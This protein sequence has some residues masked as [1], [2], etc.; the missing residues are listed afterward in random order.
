MRRWRDRHRQ[1]NSY[2]DPALKQARLEEIAVSSAGA[3]RFGGSLWKSEALMALFA[4]ERPQVVVVGRAVYV[5]TGDPAAYIRAIWWAL[6]MYWR[7]I[8]TMVWRILCTRAVL[9]GGN[10]TCRLMSVSPPNHPVISMQRAR[11]P[12]S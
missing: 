4:E 12:M 11:K 5:V 2:Y 3:W 1:L 7:D 8:G 6:V 10:A 9:Y